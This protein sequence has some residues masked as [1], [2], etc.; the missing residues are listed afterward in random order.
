M[1]YRR[2]DGRVLVAPRKAFSR[3]DVFH[4]AHGICEVCGT[5]VGVL[6]KALGTVRTM[7]GLDTRALH[8]AMRANGWHPF[9]P[10][11][12]VD[13]RVPLWE[14]GEDMASNLCLLCQRCHAQKTRT[15][16]ARHGRKLRSD[17]RR[18]DRRD[19]GGW[20]AGAGR[21]P[22]LRRQGLDRVLTCPRCGSVLPLTMIWRGKVFRHRPSGVP[23]DQ[24]NTSLAGRVGASNQRGPAARADR[25]PAVGQERSQQEAAVA[26]EESSHGRG[27]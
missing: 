19:R 26:R 16:A 14:G 8:A 22:R 15:E 2:P 17:R 24:A 13:H 18:T 25:E 20:C 6:E 10:L 23:G 27:P 4:A 11:W 7:L 9:R 21:R 1:T 5:D 12:E 3:L